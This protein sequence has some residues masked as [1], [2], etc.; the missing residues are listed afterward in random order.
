VDFFTFIVI[1]VFVYNLFAKKDKR[2][3]RRQRSAEDTER[4]LQ[5][6][7]RTEMQ[8]A[9]TKQP[10]PTRG[11]FFGNLEKQIRDAAEMI[12]QELQGQS[13]Q[14]QKTSHPKTYR[15]VTDSRSIS[16]NKNTK[17]DEQN[18]SVWGQ[19]GSSNYDRYVSTQ[20]T[21]GVEGIAGQEGT[22]GTEGS[23]YASRQNKQKT[24][25]VQEEIGSSP[26][27]SEEIYEGTLAVSS[28]AIVQG[29]IWAEVL[30]EPKGKRGISRR[31]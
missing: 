21:Q 30:K 2:P 19:E 20:G 25:I 31:S 3:V 26:I 27:Y 9:R 23:F 1:A 6:Q 29:I 11:G 10:E 12:E 14:S 17:I 15:R 28:S 5:P 24:A 8:P 7:A 16:G 22:W 18:E 4:P 13:D